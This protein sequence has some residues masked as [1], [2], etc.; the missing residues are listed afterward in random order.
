[1]YCLEV[2][3]LEGSPLWHEKQRATRKFGLLCGAQI[4]EPIG[5]I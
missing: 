1:M 2:T 4:A 3:T 5:S